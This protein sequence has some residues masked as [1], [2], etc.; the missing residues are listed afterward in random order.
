M[1]PVSHRQCLGE[2]EGEILI[3]MCIVCIITIFLIQ[4]FEPSHPSSSQA[5]CGWIWDCL[6]WVTQ[7]LT[8][9][10][11]LHVKFWEEKSSDC[12]SYFFFPPSPHFLLPFS[13]QKLFLAV[14]C[15][16]GPRADADGDCEG[17]RADLQDFAQ[18]TP[19]LNSSS[20]LT[21]P[22]ASVLH[23]SHQESGCKPLL[24]LEKPHLYHC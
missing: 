9:L 7:T 21:H 22:K 17:E 11:N 16:P 15:T 19:A 20:H 12:N 23:W 13:N 18:P 8:C 5:L 3:S 4:E 14:L 24:S 1:F 2:L 10:P 6:Q